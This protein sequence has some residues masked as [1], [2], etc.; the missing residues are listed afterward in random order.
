MAKLSNPDWSDAP[1][2]RKIADLIKLPSGYA[3]RMAQH[4]QGMAAA[5]FL[6]KQGEYA[7]CAVWWGYMT[8]WKRARWQRCEA[9]LSNRKEASGFWLFWYCWQAQGLSQQI[10]AKGTP[11]PISP[12]S[13]RATNPNASPWDYTP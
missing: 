10:A 5:A 11:Y 9:K 2:L 4:A 13:R 3:A 1:S 12:C 6:A 7:E 8:E